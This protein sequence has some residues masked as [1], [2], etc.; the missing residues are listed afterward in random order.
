MIDRDIQVQRWT[1][2]LGL[3]DGTGDG[4][5]VTVRGARIDRPTG[6]IT[7]TEAYL[8]S[9]RDYEY[10][11]WTSPTVPSEFPIASLVGS[12]TASTPGR[13]WVE[14]S[15]RGTL[16]DG[17]T[18]KWYGLGE[19][20]A[21]DFEISRTS[22]A[23]QQDQDGDVR[24][25]VFTAAD[26]HE[27]SA[28]QVRLR[29]YRPVGSQE[30]PV[31]H[32]IG[33][34][35][36]GRYDP[37]AD[38]PSTPVRALG[39]TLPVPRYSQRVHAGRYPQWDN[40][41]ASWCS[42]TSVSMVLS[43]WH[44]G[45]G[46]ADYAW[47]EPTYIDPQIAYAA[48]NTYDHSYAGCGNWTFNTAYAGRFGLDAFVT[49]LRSLNEVEAFI[50]AGIPLV[51]SAAYRVGDVP[52]ADYNTR[53]HLLLVVGFTEDGDPIMN[54]P[55]AADNHAVRKVFGR[56]EFESAWRHASGGLAYVIRPAHVP[57]PARPSQPNW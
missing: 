53:G 33:A 25:D 44:T 28:W 17:R 36:S 15:V 34:V 52:G 16:P 6:R 21:D 41:G 49:R 47:I 11:T 35:A 4:I 55:A 12:F 30:S 18:T 37:D 9:T 14:M 8:K 38:P 5:T 40:G 19:W 7:R 56:A 20:A 26:G 54:D 22:I 43:Y 57:L 45:P 51:L 42:P 13:T 39:T 46:P 24:T 3:G 48:R 1:D 2:A 27:L 23:G 10:A 32:S 29:L 50:D 31:L